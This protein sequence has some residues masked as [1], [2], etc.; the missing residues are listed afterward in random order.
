[1]VLFAFDDTLFCNS[2]A[3]AAYSFLRRAFFL[4]ELQPQQHQYQAWADR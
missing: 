4:E 3:Q 1:M 2:V